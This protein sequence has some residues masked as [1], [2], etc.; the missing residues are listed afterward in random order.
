MH[1]QEVNAEVQRG[2]QRLE[3]VKAELRT[4]K[5]ALDQSQEKI[6]FLSRRLQQSESL[7]QAPK[8]RGDAAVDTAPVSILPHKAS[9]SQLLHP[10][11]TSEPAES[12]DLSLT[13]ESGVGETERKLSERVTELEREV[14]ACVCVSAR[15]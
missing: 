7:L 2:S 12:R 15:V 5:E 8:G 14:C 13:C 9:N 10:G 11:Q 4:A 6:Q 3:R 1:Y